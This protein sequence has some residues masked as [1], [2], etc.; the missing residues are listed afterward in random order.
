MAYWYLIVCTIPNFFVS[1][2]IV[3]IFNITFYGK[4]NPNRSSLRLFFCTHKPIN[5][6]LEG[7]SVLFGIG[8][9]DKL[10]EKVSFC[11]IFWN[12]VNFFYSSVLLYSQTHTQS[13]DEIV[14]IIKL[15]LMERNRVLK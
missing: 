13:G 8:F 5:D 1:F 9:V 14:K 10:D 2:M 3:S 6:I 7:E 12:G 15:S 11:I 4:F